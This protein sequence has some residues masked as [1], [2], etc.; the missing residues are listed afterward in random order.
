MV[1]DEVIAFAEKAGYR[2]VAEE[3]REAKSRAAACLYT[4][5][6]MRLGRATEATLYAAAREF[7]VS[8]Q[9]HI[10][11]LAN[12]Q[13]KLRGLELRILTHQTTDKVKELSALS[14]QLCEAIIA[15]LESEVS[16]K[17][18]EG[19]RPRGNDSILKALTEA[20]DGKEAKRRLGMTNGALQSI[21]KRRNAG[22]H[23][24]LSGDAQETD[25]S[26][27]PD[28]ATEF[29]AFIKTVIEV[30]IGERARR[31]II[32]ERGRTSPIGSWASNSA[33]TIESGQITQAELG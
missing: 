9:L 15:L 4:E 26:E 29:Q 31:L 19:P 30:A 20:I 21:M 8:L 6:V 24:S 23:A 18:S 7:E 10:P 14:T 5:A 25:P 28:L 2:A 3:L 16:R 22:A 27:F 11:Q 17:G 13:D 1:S 32:Q 33:G 12:L